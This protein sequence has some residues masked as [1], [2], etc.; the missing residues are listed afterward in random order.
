MK[1]F[2]QDDLES[3]HSAIENLLRK[4]SWWTA[5]IKTV[6]RSLVYA[7]QLNGH[8]DQEYKDYGVDSKRLTE[9]QLNEAITQAK[10][11]KVTADD[12]IKDLEAVLT[13]SRESIPYDPNSK[14]PTYFAPEYVL[15]PAPPEK[16]RYGYSRPDEAERDRDDWKSRFSDN[17]KP[18]AERDR[19]DRSRHPYQKDISRID[20]MLTQLR[21]IGAEQTPRIFKTSPQHQTTKQECRS[22]S[23]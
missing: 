9:S 21:G 16:D 14:K 22:G 5:L 13:T 17:K 23:R 8:R 3:M 12:V 2:T 7:P 11:I 1:P 15:N 10:Q 19:D 20:T 18:K 6:N 4:L